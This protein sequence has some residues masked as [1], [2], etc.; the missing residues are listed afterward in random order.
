MFL[1]I[2][3]FELLFSKLVGKLLLNSN[4]SLLHPD[5]FFFLILI[6]VFVSLVLV[7]VL[8]H[9]NEQT[10]PIPQRTPRGRGFGFFL[11]ITTSCIFLATTFTF[12]FGSV[13]HAAG[14][15]PD[16]NAGASGS[17]GARD[18][19]PAAPQI[20]PVEEFFLE[21]DPLDEA[22]RWEEH[23]RMVAFYNLVQDKHFTEF[24]IQS[25]VGKI[26]FI[27]GQV[28][29]Q[30]RADG[31]SNHKIFRLKEDIR[32]AIFFDQ[33]ECLLSP[34]KHE[35]LIEEIHREGGVAR[36]A[37]Y[38]KAKE[39]GFMYDVELLEQRMLRRTGNQR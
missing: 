27:E 4:F 31:W 26:F 33:N 16:L 2:T 17:G 30:L 11:A 36:C 29:E 9:F 15:D 38:V 7:F 6:L 37:F 32:T 22:T 19:N 25:L 20:I 10:N 39:L 5:I 35:E 1:M 12:G 13:A 24:E 3:R 18:A 28:V 23:Q 34:S 14:H 21:P 8:W